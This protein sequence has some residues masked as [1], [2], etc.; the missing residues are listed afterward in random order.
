[1]KTASSGRRCSRGTR[2]AAGPLRRPMRGMPQALTVQ[3]LAP[4]PVGHRVQVLRVRYWST[5]IFGGP[6]SWTE[7]SQPVLVD[8]ETGVAYCYGTLASKLSLAPLGFLPDSGYQVA[9]QKEARVTAC[10]VA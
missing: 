1:M 2:C 8:L 10:L 9:A 4:V 6:G 5:P 3:F 7:D